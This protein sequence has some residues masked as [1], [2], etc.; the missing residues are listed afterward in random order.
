[1]PI[2]YFGNIG[3]NDLLMKHFKTDYNGLLDALNV[4]FRGM[5]AP[6]AGK[7][8]FPKREGRIVSDVYGFYCKWIEHSTGGYWD[9]CDFPLQDAEPEVIAGFPVPDPA[10]FDYGAI[11][12]AIKMFPGR[13]LHVGNGGFA[14]VINSTGR[15]MGMEQTLMNLLTGD[16]A[17]LT[18]INR[19]TDME[20]A[21]LDESI[22]RAKG[23]ADFLWMGEDLGTQIAPMVSLEMYRKVMRPIHQRFV[24]LAKCHKLPVMIHT[25]G[26][27]SW[28]Y[29]DFVEMG[30]DAVDTLQPEAT[31]MNPEYL[32]KHFGGKLSFHGSISTAGPLAYGTPDEVD[33][34]VR[35]KC[36]IYR[37]TRSY[38]ISPTHSIQD[39]SPMENVLRM[40]ECAI[41]YGK[42]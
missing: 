42:Y 11:D 8:L 16:E 13:A 23:R 19:R 34:D 26:A 6:Y 38:M 39:N 12:A 35:A 1:M 5:Y 15:V 2:D 3:I 4:D 36:D 21:T 17:T 40:Y 20:I 32:I 7:L 37:P 18:Y 10:H 25:C 14:D 28:A 9:F 22:K 24:D 33:A 27:S 41:K 30:I 31:N 29:N